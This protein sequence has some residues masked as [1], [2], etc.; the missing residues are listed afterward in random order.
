MGRIIHSLELEKLMER[1]S[2]YLFEYEKSYPYLRYLSEDD[3]NKLYECPESNYDYYKLYMDFLDKELNFIL[4]EDDFNE[5][6]RYAL[7]DVYTFYKCVKEH[8]IK[9]PY[10]V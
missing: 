9:L 2:D 5:V 10:E 6:F 4:Y 7:E 8:N 3:Y 1:F